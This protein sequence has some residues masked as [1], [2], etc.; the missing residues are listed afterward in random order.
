MDSAERIAG[1]LRQAEA[2]VRQGMS[3]S[4]FCRGQVWASVG[5]SAGGWDDWAGS[6]AVPGTSS[7]APLASGR[8]AFAAAVPMS[9]R[10]PGALMVGRFGG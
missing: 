10:A 5:T 3:V 1:L 4:D 2:D 7:E 6:V 8:M 9:A